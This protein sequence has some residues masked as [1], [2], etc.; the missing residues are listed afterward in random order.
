MNPVLQDQTFFQNLSSEK[1][2]FIYEIVEGSKSIHNKNEFIPFFKDM[3]QKS[4][5]RNIRFT[6]EEMQFIIRA[7]KEQATPAENAAI[8]KIVQY[9][10]QKST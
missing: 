4:N 7:V 2:E 1:K 6:P 3:L 5:E 9:A 10:Q 8:D